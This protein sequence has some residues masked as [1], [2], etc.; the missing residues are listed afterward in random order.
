MKTVRKNKFEVEYAKLI[1]ESCREGDDQLSVSLLE[2][3]GSGP[4][5]GLMRGRWHLVDPVQGK[6]RQKRGLRIA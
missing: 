5:L 3:S 6:Q 1:I 2:D 4:Y